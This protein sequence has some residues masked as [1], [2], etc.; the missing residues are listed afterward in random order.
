MTR[1]DADPNTDAHFRYLVDSVKGH[2]IFGMDLEGRITSWNPGAERIKGWRADEILGRHFRVLFPP[3]LRAVGHPERELRHALEHGRYSGEET[4]QRKDGTLFIANVNLY[5]LRDDANRPTGFVK[6]TEDVT[7]RKRQEEALR[8]NEAR[9]K[10]LLAALEEGIC[11]YDAQGVIQ[12]ANSAAQRLTGM[13]AEALVGRSVDDADWDVVNED[14]TPCPPEEIPTRR[15]IERGEEVRGRV[16]GIRGV[17]GRRLWISINSRPIL[18]DEG[19][20]TG[21]VTSFFDVS[22]RREADAERTRLHAAE[23]TARAQAEADRHRLFSIFQYAPLAIAIFRGPRHVIEFANPVQCRIWGRAPD[24]LVGRPVAE[25]LPE[26]AEQGLVERVFDPV[27]HHGESMVMTEAPLSLPKLAGDGTLEMGYY[28]FVHVPTRALEGTVDGFMSVAWDVTASVAARRKSEALTEELAE[29]HAF[30]RQLIGLVSHDLRNPLS[31]ILLTAAAMARRNELDPAQAQSVLRI[32]S[33]A[34]R[35]ARLVQDL[36]D[37]TRARM[38][39][40]IPVAPRPADLHAVT[41][42]VLDEIEAAHPGRQLVL[43][44]RGDGHGELDPERLAQV[45]QNLL[46]NAVKYSRPGSPIHVVSHG[47]DG[48][49]TICVHNEGEPLAPEQLP[50]IFEPLQRARADRDVTHRSM[51]LG[52]YIVKHITEAHGGTVTVQSDAQTGTTFTV[53]LPRVTPR[54]GGA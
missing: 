52:L 4:R 16:M 13:P 48:A 10:A 32:Q 15:S 50:R 24:S 17:K 19:R 46:V 31:A 54:G 7:E 18:D 3:E 33:A 35:A 23:R 47:E 14:G 21:A 40:S 53:R 1:L 34:E 39:G 45:L 30:E 49:L 43:E 44:Q 36:L 12:F 20:I 38:T 27:F 5:V 9:L 2:A 28:N 37:F 6:V 26:L 8:A 25:A 29:R 22:E 42:K 11:V 41:R 51:G